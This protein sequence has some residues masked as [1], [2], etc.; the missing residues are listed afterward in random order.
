MIKRKNSFYCLYKTTSVQGQYQITLLAQKAGV[1]S[2]D[3]LFEKAAEFDVEN[4]FTPSGGNWKQIEQFLSEL[5]KKRSYESVWLLELEKYNREVQSIQHA[6]K[7]YSIFEKNGKCYP[8]EKE[9]RN[10]RER[11]LK[12]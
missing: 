11:F 4:I 12:I 5:L 7:V 8:N 1:V 2:P 9:K 3:Y 6:S 10:L